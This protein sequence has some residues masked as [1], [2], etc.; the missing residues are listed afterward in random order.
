MN[1]L[2]SDDLDIIPPIIKPAKIYF[3]FLAKLHIQGECRKSGGVKQ[4]K[5]VLF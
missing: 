4:P 3:S 1:Y 2:I 5:D